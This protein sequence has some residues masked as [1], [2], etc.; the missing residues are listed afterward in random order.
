M[1]KFSSDNILAAH[2]DQWPR[3]PYLAYLPVLYTFEWRW[4]DQPEPSDFEQN[5]SREWWR[6]LRCLEN[7]G[8]KPIIPLHTDNL[9]EVLHADVDERRRRPTRGRL[10]HLLKEII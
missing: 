5:F 6:F 2:P 8:F 1:T 7:L 9:W 4:K 3:E 10:Y